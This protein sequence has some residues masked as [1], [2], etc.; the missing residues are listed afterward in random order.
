MANDGVEDLGWLTYRVGL[1]FGG[2]N[3]S[4][5]L[6]IVPPE[7]MV[8]PTRNL[9]LSN[10]GRE[11]RGGSSILGSTITGTPQ[12][13]G[14]FQYRKISGTTQVLSHCADGVIYKDY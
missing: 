11:K 3:G 7:G 9:D 5:N 2:F 6:D 13:L 10:G 12:I 14:H 4:P 8:H 1:G